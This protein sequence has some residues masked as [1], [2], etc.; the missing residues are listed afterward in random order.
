[1]T[2]FTRAIELD[3]N[4]ARAYAEKGN[5]LTRAGRPS[6]AIPLAEKAIKLSP[7]DPALGAFY[8]I[9]GRAYFYMGNYH[10]AIPWLQKSV[11]VRPNMWYNRLYLV[12]AYALSNKNEDALKAL[13]EFTARREFAGYT[14]ERVKSNEEAVPADNP[15]VVAGR[16]KLHEGLQMAGMVER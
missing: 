2:A 1:L 15:V 13:H 14:L 9:I 12:S 4:F 16:E 11:S 10:N 5:E 8:W 3:P 7:R 6:E